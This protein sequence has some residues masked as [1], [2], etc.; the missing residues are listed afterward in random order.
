MNAFVGHNVHKGNTKNWY[1]EKPGTG[2]RKRGNPGYPGVLPKG[3]VK[4]TAKR[5]QRIQSKHQV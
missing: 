3:T 5:S 4:K 2:I 1:P